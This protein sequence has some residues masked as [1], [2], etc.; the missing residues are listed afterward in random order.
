[1]EPCLSCIEDAKFGY[2]I[3]NALMRRVY[4]LQNRAMRIINFKRFRDSVNP[5]YVKFKVVKLEDYIS[6]L[7]YLFAYNNFASDLP[8]TFS[9]FIS[10]RIDTTLVQQQIMN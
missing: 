4:T 8:S 5:L 10:L 7:N 1:M 6:I 9:I 2:K 3:K